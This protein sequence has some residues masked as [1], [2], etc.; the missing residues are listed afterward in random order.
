MPLV[1]SGSTGIVEGNIADSAI[2]TPKIANG[3][4]VAADLHTTAIQD[5]LGYTPASK[6]GETFTGN[7]A[8]AYDGFPALKFKNAAGADEAEIYCGTGANDLNIVN[9]NTA[10]INFNTASSTRF[11]I[12]GNGTLRLAHSYSGGGS[13][14]TAAPLDTTK[15]SAIVYAFG[16]ENAFRNVSFG[17]WHL[18]YAQTNNSWSIAQSTQTTQGNG[19]GTVTLG[20]NGNFISLGFAVSSIGGWM[21]NIM[22][23]GD[24]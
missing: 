13:T 4:V 1:L 10:P 22:Y 16:N 9:Y 14:S 2:T 11:T 19:Y 5:K 7:L 24:Y 15:R 18:V 3:A 20:I 21:L 23:F 6:A 17:T 12:N 8:I